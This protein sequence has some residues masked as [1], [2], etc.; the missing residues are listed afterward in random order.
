VAISEEVEK[1]R[2]I[3]TKFAG[4]TDVARGPSAPDGTTTAAFGAFGQSD[5]E[6][7]R[8]G[9]GAQGDH[10]DQSASFEDFLEVVLRDPSKL[11]S[12]TSS[13]IL[14]RT[15]PSLSSYPRLRASTAGRP[16]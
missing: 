15:I 2:Y 10:I 4:G 13:L 5:G 8:A 7:A 3:G 11:S 9:A 6:R 1:H 14:F 12:L 16:R